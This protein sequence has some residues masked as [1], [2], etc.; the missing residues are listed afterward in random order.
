M[1]SEKVYFFD[2]PA[3]C[4]LEELGMTLTWDG[5]KQKVVASKGNLEI[6]MTIGQSTA[7]VNGLS[8]ILT[9]P[10]ELRNERTYVPLRWL[11]ESVNANVEWDQQTNKVRIT[12]H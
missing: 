12:T 4:L 7:L 5:E 3:W 2:L 10:P 6:D 8:Q 11:A 1:K 9:R